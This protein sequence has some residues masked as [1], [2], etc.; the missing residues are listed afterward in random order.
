MNRDGVFSY[1]NDC[2]NDYA[3][4]NIS[5]DDVDNAL[6]QAKLGKSC[7]VDGLAAAHFIYA[8]N[9]AKI[10]LSILFTSC[11]PHGYLPDS[12]MKSAIIPII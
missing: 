3:A 9:C 6:R 1:L 10:Y 5:F 8:S 7:G 12:L 2:S 11:I 4:I